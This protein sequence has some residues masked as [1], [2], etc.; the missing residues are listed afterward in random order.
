MVPL[1]AAGLLL[2]CRSGTASAREVAGSNGAL[3]LGLIESYYQEGDAF[4]AET[5]V[6]RFLHERPDHPRR[7]EVELVRAKLYYREG[8]YGE[9]SLMLFSQLDRFPEGNASLQA[10][11]LL[12]F[13]L[14]REGR[15]DEAEDYLSVAGGRAASGASLRALRETPPDAVAPET[16]VAWS[17]WLPG[18]GFFLLD[19]PGKAFAAMGLNLF[20]IGAAAVS[21]QEDLAGAGLVFLLAELAI[22]RGG[23]DA[24]RDAAAARL[25]RLRA[26][27][28]DAWLAE[29]GEPE[30]LRFG[31]RLRFGAD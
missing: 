25:A 14:V 22:Y 12:A 26:Q 5:E 21:F 23:R 19:Q 4:R 2:P 11:R 28:S 16:A 29:Q 8:R 15:L 20:F 24:V 6:L 9:S 17:T 30:L 3:A 7:E 31:I 18:S 13:S 27:R 10:R 1:V